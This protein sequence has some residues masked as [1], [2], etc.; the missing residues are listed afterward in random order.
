MEG[1]TDEDLV[2]RAVTDRGGERG[3]D[4]ASRLFQRYEERVYIWCLRYV[5]GHDAAVELAQEVLLR[6]Y[7]SLGSFQGRSRFSSWLY[8]IAR[9]QCLNALRPVSLL[10]DDEAEP[11]QLPGLEPGPDE[12]LEGAEW[13]ARLL[14]LIRTTLNPLE[15]EALWLRCIEKVPVDEITHMLNISTASGARGVLQS[16]RRRLRAA[17]ER[18]EP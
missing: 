14:D 17:L 18:A 13:E 8:A 2:A 1:A 5:R 15:Q 6:A 7:R 10:R 12:V 16:A 9:N 3:R 4:A 11:D